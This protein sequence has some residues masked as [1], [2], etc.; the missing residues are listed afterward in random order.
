VKLVLPVSSNIFGVVTQRKHYV[1]IITSHAT[2]TQKLLLDSNRILKGSMYLGYIFPLNLDIF[3]PY[4]GLTFRYAM[5]PIW[6]SHSSSSGLCNSSVYSFLS[7][8]DLC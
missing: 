7:S 3:N 5:S 1:L 4:I 8:N 6:G 2:L